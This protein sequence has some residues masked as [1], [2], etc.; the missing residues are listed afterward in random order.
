MLWGSRFRVHHRLAASYRHGRV[1]LAG[2]AA[3]VHSPAGGQGMNTG[4]PDAMALAPLLADALRTDEMTGLDAYQAVR[5][6]VA[7]PV[8]TTTDRLTRAAAVRNPLLRRVRNLAFGAANHVERGKR[9]LALDLSVLNTRT[10]VEV[11]PRAGE[12]SP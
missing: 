1:F 10:P 11:A 12:N 3:H 5:R 9:H 2:D 6:P 7:Q 4:I 8:I